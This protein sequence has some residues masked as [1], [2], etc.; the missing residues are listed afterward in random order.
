MTEN[1][2][3]PVGDQGPGTGA[4][5]PYGSPAA[6][7]P[8]SPAAPQYGA[9]PA[10]YGQPPAAPGYGQPPAAPGYG[11]PPAA[12]GYGQPPVSDSDRRTWS[13]L[14]HLGG[15]LFGFIAPLIVWIIYKD[16]DAFIKDQSAEA[17]NFQI[18]VAIGYV[19]SL[20]LTIV[21]IGFVTMFAV[22]ILS[23]VFAIIGGL[24]AG[25]GER[26]R[27]PLTLRLVS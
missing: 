8:G 13:M 5:P 17:L 22:W 4:P 15:I 2:M 24:A 16:R 6:P 20:V 21:F 25:R 26:Y 3:P 12:P 10:G 19:A 9:P 27:Y 18:T 14:S 11:Q 7:Q 23:I 1:P